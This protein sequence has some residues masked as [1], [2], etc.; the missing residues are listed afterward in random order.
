MRVNTFRTVL[1]GAAKRAV[2]FATAG[3]VAAT[4]LLSSGEAPAAAL[5]Y[6]FSG[7][8][9]ATFNDAG[10]ASPPGFSISY[11]LN[12]GADGV[13]LPNLSSAPFSIAGG[14]MT[15]G[16][17]QAHFPVGDVFLTLDTGIG[18]AV[19]QEADADVAIVSFF[20][21]DS[22]EPYFGKGLVRFEVISAVA[23]GTLPDDDAAGALLIDHE[24]FYFQMHFSDDT[25][26][27]GSIAD[28]S[29]QVT[30]IPAPSALTLML[31]ACAP[32]AAM[33]RR[34]SAR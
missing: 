33:R 18:N 27:G 3:F 4:L 6:T 2:Q 28:V 1:S 17:S 19:F 22:S 11:V 30:G 29:V 25:L 14:S 8:T 20:H 26:I 31:A 9:I 34:R 16:A 32:V 24:R 13:S 7:T 10:I 21:D 23:G 12:L 15:I 5:R